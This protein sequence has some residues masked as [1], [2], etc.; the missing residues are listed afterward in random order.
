MNIRFVEKVFRAIFI[1]V[2]VV[3]TVG[4]P[5]TSAKAQAGCPS[6]MVS[7]WKA[8]G[9]AADSIDGNYGVLHGATFSAGKVGQSFATDLDQY[10][11]VPDNSNLHIPQNITIEAWVNPS[12]SSSDRVILSKGNSFVGDGWHMMLRD[13]NTLAVHARYGTAWEIT[14]TTDAITTGTWHHVAYTYDGSQAKLYIDGVLKALRIFSDPI[15]QNTRPLKIGTV[16]QNTHFFVGLV[17]EVA[18]YNSV[19]AESELYEHYQDGESGVSYC[20]QAPANQ[21]PVANAGGPYTAETGEVVTLD[22]SASSDPEAGALTYEWD[23]NNDGQYDD[24]SGVTATISFDQASEYTVGLRVTDPLGLMSTDT[25]T[26]TVS[27][28]APVDSDGDGIEDGADNCPTVSNPGQEDADND[29]V[30]DVC[31]NCPST[32]NPDQT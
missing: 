21:P 15:E 6:S 10:V 25:A 4:V 13:N 14:E 2:F 17:D 12:T 32:A 22:A 20:E 29:G 28:P 31:D 23:L 8:D 16:D 7:Y 24:A 3:G 30:G 1:F 26:I 19:L 9:D 27:N 5:G 18:V 11:E